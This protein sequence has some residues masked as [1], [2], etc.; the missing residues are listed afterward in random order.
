[1]VDASRG[2]KR[3]WNPGRRARVVLLVGLLSLLAVEALLR[4]R[5][6]LKYGTLSTTFYQLEE[7]PA[8][9]LEIPRRGSVVGPIRINSLGFRGPELESPKPEG[10]ARLAFLGGSTTFC[11]EASSLA[12]TWPD[13]V[14]QGLAARHPERTF[15]YVNGGAGGYSTEQSL[16]NLEHRVAPLEPDVVLV[17]HATNDL[18]QDTRALAAQR[19]LYDPEEKEQGFLGRWSLTWF[20]IEKN[21]RFQSRKKDEGGEKLAYDATELAQVF[22]ARL[23]QLVRDAQELGALVVLPTFSHRARRDQGPE[24]RREASSSSLY[25]MPYLDVEGILAGFEAYNTVIRDVAAETGALLVEGEEEIPGDA[26]HFA[27]SV[28]L[29]DV[30]CERMAQRVLAALEEDGVLERFLAER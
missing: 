27:D 29:T 3:A 12:T 26:V 30:G 23:E 13:R 22:R 7:D 15:D 24:A 11:A 17:Y 1:M 14:V 9:G 10:R 20:L 25:Y 21:L 6:W 2:G 18:T 4:A 5:Q 19:G 16:L 28:H 8:S